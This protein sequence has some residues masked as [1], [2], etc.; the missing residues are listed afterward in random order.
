MKKNLLIALL[1]F[2]PL[3]SFSQT[4]KPISGFLGIKFG[5]T[6]LAVIAAMKAKGAKFNAA[7]SDNSVLV[8]DKVKLGSR[9]AIA[10]LVYLT[11]GKAYSALFVF[12][13]EDEPQISDYY[14]SLVNDIN[15]IYGIGES[16][17]NI[18]SPFKDGDGH[19]LLA[20]QQGY[21]TIYTDW[22]SGA[23]S[24]EVAINK[25]S[26]K[27]IVVLN[28]QDGA[29]ADAAESKKKAKEKEDF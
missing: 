28:Y 25:K 27:L 10:F 7:S 14:Q 3:C 11:S 5:S 1:F 12:M 15:D 8:F 4:T 18:Q 17:K 21:A 24:I 6:K 13:P 9:D 19:E 23:N 26:D 20:L 22:K 2:I 16:T 29:L